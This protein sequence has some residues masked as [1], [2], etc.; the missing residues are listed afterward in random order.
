MNDEKTPKLPNGP[1][2]MTPA[3]ARA[4]AMRQMAF[5]RLMVARSRAARAKWAAS[6][7]KPRPKSAD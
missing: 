5:A 6:R 2:A 3:R 1:V 7:P 4:E